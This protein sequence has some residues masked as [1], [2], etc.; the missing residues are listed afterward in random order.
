MQIEVTNNSILSLKPE[1]Q[2]DHIVL[3]FLVGELRKNNVLHVAHRQWSVQKIE[4]P[5]T[6]NNRSGSANDKA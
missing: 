3:D 2:A 6:I 1:N 5:L 4:L